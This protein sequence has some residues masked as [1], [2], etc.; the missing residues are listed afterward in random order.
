MKEWTVS[1]G[2]ECGPVFCSGFFAPA[3]GEIG[4]TNKENYRFAICHNARTSTGVYRCAAESFIY[5]DG[6]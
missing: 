1:A 4:A 6:E 5:T 3:P 2:A